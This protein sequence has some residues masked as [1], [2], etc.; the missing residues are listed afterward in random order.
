MNK[1]F[2]HISTTNE[3][4][5]K[6]ILSESLSDTKELGLKIGKNLS[7]G[8]IILL[9][10]DLGA[11]KTELVRYITLGSG[12]DSFVRSPTFVLI[13]NYEGSL[14]ITHCD[15]YRIEDG[16][17]TEE[18]GIEE[19]FDNS[20]VLIEWPEKI[21]N[22]LPND[23]VIVKIFFSKKETERKIMLYSTGENSKKLIGGII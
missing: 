6:T 1:I 20:A 17:Q 4:Y 11:G 5:E 18:L 10:G 15:F 2:K 3:I 16:V 12:N 8:N 7:T 21:S 9:S 19:Y 23:C 14:D 22:N 13:N